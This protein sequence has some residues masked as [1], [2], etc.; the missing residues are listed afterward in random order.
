MEAVK[1]LAVDALTERDFGT[2]ITKLQL[3]KDLGVQV[4]FSESMRALITRNEPLGALEYQTLD[5]RHVLQVID[6]R[7]RAHT[8]RRYNSG[9]LTHIRDERGELPESVSLSDRLASLLCIDEIHDPN[10]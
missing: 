6:L 10:M 2:S 8:R 3:A 5:M 1:A 4:W 9:Q 7:E